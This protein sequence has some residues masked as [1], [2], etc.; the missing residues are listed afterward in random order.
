MEI[1]NI[2]CSCFLIKIGDGKRTSFWEDY[3][4][5]DSNLQK[6]IPRLFSTSLNRTIN[7]S[8]AIGSGITSLSFRRTLVGVLKDQCLQL[9]EI[10]AGVTLSTEP[11]RLVWKITNFGSFSRHADK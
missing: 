4:I 9:R 7:V 10:L 1:K 5:A 11:D 6:K 8:D 2:F 3:W